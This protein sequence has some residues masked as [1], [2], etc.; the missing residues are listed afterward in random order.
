MYIYSAALGQATR[1]AADVEDGM[2]YATSRDGRHGNARNFRRDVMPRLEH[3][4]ELIA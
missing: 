1:P 4:F 3:L 2:P